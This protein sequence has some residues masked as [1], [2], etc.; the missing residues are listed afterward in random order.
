[1]SGADNTA[2]APGRILINV[3]HI[4]DTLLATP[5]VRALATAWPEAEITLAP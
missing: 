4:G 2:P 5:A 1:L 3:T